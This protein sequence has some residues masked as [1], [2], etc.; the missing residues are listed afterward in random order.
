V[1]ASDARRARSAALAVEVA[2]RHVPNA[3]HPGITYTL[4]VLCAGA[5]LFGFWLDARSNEKRWGRWRR[6]SLVFQLGAIAA[7]Y[8]V[9][10]PGRGV[11]GRAAIAAGV[12][13]GHPVML[14]MFSNY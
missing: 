9:L 5:V 11:D 7:A 6:F 4:L 12:A 8:L 13:S 14:E 10:R 1:G 3:M 2:P